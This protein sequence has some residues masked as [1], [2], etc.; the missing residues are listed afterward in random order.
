MKT[1]VSHSNGTHYS[2]NEK[3]YLLNENYFNALMYLFV[4]G[5]FGLRQL[6]V[7]FEW[8]PHMG[9]IKNLIGH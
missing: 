9:L 5:S 4:I 7:R 1:N 8:A 2:V 3:E 6:H